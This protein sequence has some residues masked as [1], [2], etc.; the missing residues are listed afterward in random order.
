MRVG[1][2]TSRPPRNGLII[3]RSR[4][5]PGA[6]PSWG[7]ARSLE[8]LSV[9]V[10]LSATLAV[11]TAWA[12][13]VPMFQGPDEEAH[14][15]YA[16]SVLAAGR[17]LTVRDRYPQPD[18]NVRI[19]NPVVAWLA[20]ESGFDVVRRANSVPAPPGYG[21]ERFLS[22]VDRQAPTGV[23]QT[24]NPTILGA[25]PF[26]Y[27]WLTAG[28]MAAW[29][30]LLRGPAEL[31]FAARALSCLLL[32]SGLGF[33]YLALRAARL[34]WPRAWLVTAAFGFFPMTSFIGGLV[35]PENLAVP[36]VSSALW[37]GLRARSGARP[38]LSL[39]GMS[40]ALGLLA[41]TK[42]HYL[43]VTAT[44]LTGLLLTDARLTR[45][46][47]WRTASVGLLLAV[48]TLL[49]AAIQWWVGHGSPV[50]LA[51]SP[52]LWQISYTAVLHG[53]GGVVALPG[54][55]ARQLLATLL[56][57]YVLGSVWLSFWGNFGWVDTPL[58]SGPVWLIAGLSGATSLAFLLGLGR[59]IGSGRRILRMALRG[60]P[61]PVVA[62][63][64]ANP[65]VASFLA[66][67]ALVVALDVAS[68][69]RLGAQGRYWLPFMPGLI[70]FGTALAPRAVS[71]RWRP[72]I[73]NLVVGALTLYV[74]VGAVTAY[75]VV[76]HR[77]WQNGRSVDY[78]AQATSASGVRAAG[79]VTTA[80]PSGRNLGDP[81]VLAAH[82]APGAVV[83]V[84]V[85]GY[86]A[87]VG[88]ATD[89]EGKRPAAVAVLVDGRE[90]TRAVVGDDAAGHGTD[91]FD[92]LLQL[93]DLPEG[94]HQIA[95]RVTRS[96]RRTFDDSDV[97]QTFV[98]ASAPDPCRDWGYCIVP[99]R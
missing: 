2:P 62:A 40:V 11:A 68:E 91:G 71:P 42:M 76:A 27:Y 97:V 85:G 73:R 8:C 7:R 96:D 57:L 95:L 15:D 33:S 38:A 47:R 20:R 30:P 77:Y 25:Y 82:P 55:I 9:V 6:L 10:L 26:A 93:G 46:L 78:A 74:A 3:D 21:S 36:L 86:L 92:A 60:R 24:R 66:F 58:V 48:P 37:F 12:M 4:G 90:W 35:Q 61:R 69:L 98:V 79:A 45:A 63:I 34:S 89:G 44:A 31:F 13:T 18:P 52:V 94:E 81:S 56:D 39:A 84:P 65:M 32:T 64:F 54:A 99:R 88:W 23:P 29:R 87:I 49:M 14:F 41:V 75:H 59:C 16:Y 72:A 83:R 53:P 22:E 80:V 1:H 70:H 67:T 43:V 5:R 17:P 28:W 50:R 19:S 51:G